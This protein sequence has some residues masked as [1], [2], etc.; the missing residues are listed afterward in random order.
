MSERNQFLNQKCEHF[1]NQKPPTG[2]IDIY[3]PRATFVF[4]RAT[5][6][7]PKS[8]LFTTNFLASLHHKLLGLSST[9]FCMASLHHT[10]LGLSSPQTSWPLF[11]TNFLASLQHTFAWPLFTT[12]FLASF[13]HT[14][15]GISY[16]IRKILLEAIAINEESV[17][18]IPL[19]GAPTSFFLQ[20]SCTLQIF[21]IL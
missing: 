5:F 15:L 14:L 16:F 10:L 2:V 9:H 11:T 3:F 13:H 4:S 19:A 21:R 7:L 8:S 17:I 1:G 18:V 6:D 12:H 20:R